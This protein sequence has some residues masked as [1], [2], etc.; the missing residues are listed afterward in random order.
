MFDTTTTIWDTANND[1]MTMKIVMTMTIM[2]IR[3]DYNNDESL[4][5]QF[6]PQVVYSPIIKHCNG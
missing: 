6:Q 3:D 2:I 4:V 5:F 1:K